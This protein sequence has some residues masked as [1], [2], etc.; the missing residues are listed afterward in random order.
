MKAILYYSNNVK[1][2]RLIDA[3]WQRYRRQATQFGATL[4]AVTERRMSPLPDIEVPWEP[5]KGKMPEVVYHK[6][7]AGL[8]HLAEGCTVILADDDTMLPDEHITIETSPGAIWYNMNIAYLSER[9]FSTH[10]H[11]G[12]LSNGALVADAATLLHAA[13]RKLWEIEHNLF[14]CYEPASG[15]AGGYVSSTFRTE[16]PV[17]DWRGPWNNTWSVDPSDPCQA[18]DATTGRHPFWQDEKGWPIAAEMWRMVF[19]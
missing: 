10:C 2:Y 13:N 19:G 16:S 6:W 5:G 17:V 18:F 3:C 4:V 9:G 7:L 8:E 14:A 15:G 12:S 1:D 11:R